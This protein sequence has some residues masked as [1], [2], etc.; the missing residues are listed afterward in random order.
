MVEDAGSSPAR[1]TKLKVKPLMHN[2]GQLYYSER[3][4]RIF[5]VHEDDDLPSGERMYELIRRGGSD[6][7]PLGY[8]IITRCEMFHHLVEYDVSEHGKE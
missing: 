1:P 6:P 3:S 7:L 8:V 5:R 4:G 2:H